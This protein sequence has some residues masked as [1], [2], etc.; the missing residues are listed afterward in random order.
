MV[1]KEVKK[2]APVYGLVGV[3]S[4]VILIAMIYSFGTTQVGP[5]AGSPIHTSYTSPLTTSTEA[6]PLQSFSSYSELNSFVNSNNAASRY[7][8]TTETMPMPA[9][10]PTQGPTAEGS[11]SAFSTSSN[12]AIKDFSTTNIQVAGVDEADSVKTDGTYLYVIANNS[13]YIL[14][15]GSTDPQTAKVL[16][17]INENNTYF[18]GI[19]LSKDGKK[20]AII[21]SSYQPYIPEKREGLIVPAWGAS[22]TFLRVYDVTNKVSPTLT[23]NFTITG[24]YVN[25]R[26]IGNY[27]YLIVNENVQVNNGEV[28]LPIVF[29]GTAAFNIEPSK[30]FYSRAPDSYSTYTTIV[31]LNIVDDSKP[32]K[33]TSIMMGYSNTIYVS[34]EN[35]YLTY[36]NWN[37]ETQDTTIYRLKVNQDNLIFEAKGVVPG[38]PINQYAMDEYNGYFRIA[39][40]TWFQDNATTSDGA[41]FKVSRQLNSLYVLNMNLN[42]IGRL[43]RFK[44]DESIYAA[45]FMGNKCYVVTFKQVDPFFVIDLSSPNAPKVVGELKIPG[46]SSYLHPYDENH[47]IGVGKEN[48]TLKLSLFDVTNVNAPTEAAKYIINA[49]YVDSSAIYDPHA[50]L[51]DRQKQLLVIPVS[52]ND[53]PTVFIREPPTSI[54]SSIRMPESNYWQGAYIFSININ[55]GFTLKGKVTHMDNTTTQNQETYWMS[56]NYWINRALYI[57]NTLYTL[58]N[59][60]VQLNSLN[61][62]ALLAKIELN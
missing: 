30:I 48:S 61:N 32:Q 40:T 16:A 62:L 56:S 22:T 8:V 18:S 58:S 34:A 6:A 33:E 51:F 12:G 4:A 5:F 57:D 11:I 15:A 38:Y 17:K 55:S 31:S 43:E 21:G 36:Q 60:R 37:G 46:Y 52:I 19:Y 3:L 2:K 13:V 47:I 41:V 25:S 9:P 14:D 49:A 23:R 20:L 24:N 26:M 45:R 50:F 44:M 10:A 29:S 42:I 59:Y 7:Y 28:N 39:V 53:A 35:I 54:D 1:Q 27:V